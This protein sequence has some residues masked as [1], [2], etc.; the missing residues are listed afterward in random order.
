MWQLKVRM[1]AEAYLRGEY[2]L[3]SDLYRDLGS[4]LK[5][6]Y[7]KLI[8]EVCRRRAARSVRAGSIHRGRDIR[9]RSRPALEL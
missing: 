6:Q 4:R 5:E 7:F 9:H 2:F 3:S 1:A 8:I